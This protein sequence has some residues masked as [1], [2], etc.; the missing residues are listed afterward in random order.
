MSILIIRHGETALNAARVVQPPST[1]LNAQGQEQAELLATRLTQFKL[2]RIISSDYTRAHMTAVAVQQHQE[3]PVELEP[4]L[5]E[6]NFGDIRGTPY[7]ELTTDIFDPD[8]NP[9]NGESLGIFDARVSVAWAKM[10][11]IA[12]NMTSHLALITHGL[13]CKS[14]V[15]HQLRQNTKLS[16]KELDF[17]NTSLTIVE[18]DIPWKILRFAC[19]DHLRNKKSLGTAV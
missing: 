8:F 6:R 15:K 11:R 1:P 19:T 18:S 13:V 10:I 4:L 9:P 12:V 7:S 16:E 3:V 17:G 2:G 5:R 14:I